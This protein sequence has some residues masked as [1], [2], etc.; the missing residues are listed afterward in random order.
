MEGWLGV[1][2][3][4]LFEYSHVRLFPFVVSLPWCACIAPF[5]VSLS[6]H[7]IWP[8]MDGRA[9]ARNASNPGASRSR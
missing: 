6:N 2:L 9:E 5:L 4:W 3:Y 7:E 8:S 1:T